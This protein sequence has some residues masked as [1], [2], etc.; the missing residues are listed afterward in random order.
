[1]HRIVPQLVRVIQIFPT[2]A[3]RQP[4]LPQH[5]FRSVPHLPFLTLIRDPTRDRSNQ[6]Q[7]PVHFPHHEQ[8]RMA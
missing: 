3:Q 1:V 2:G 6:T 4:P 7:F 8:S 5:R